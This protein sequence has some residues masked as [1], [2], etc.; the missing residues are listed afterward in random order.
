M[1]G[2]E[3]SIFKI[4]MI[5][6]NRKNLFGFISEDFRFS[7]EKSPPA[8]LLIFIGDMT[9]LG[10]SAF[11]NWIL[12]AVKK[13]L[14]RYIWGPNPTITKSPQLHFITRT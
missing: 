8:K 4:S 1:Q 7:V 6:S 11:M 12:S 14:V 2:M 5:I 9:T 13:N 10:R 3:R